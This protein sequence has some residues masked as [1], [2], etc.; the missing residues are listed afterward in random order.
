MKSLKSESWRHHLFYE[1]SP[2]FVDNYEAT[3]EE[4]V[5]YEISYFLDSPRTRELHGNDRL[6]LYVMC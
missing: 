1:T 4:S 6:P 3:I 5:E 2:R